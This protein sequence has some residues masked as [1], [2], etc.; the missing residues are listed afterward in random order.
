MAIVR[1]A[2]VL[3]FRR[4]SE[5]TGIEVLLGHPGGPLFARRDD[6]AWSI[7]K[8]LYKT[9]EEPRAAAYREFTEETGL[10]V[11]PGREITLGEARM[12]TGKRLTV[13]AV[14]GDLDPA[15]AHSNT[16]EMEWPPRSGR[17]G[18]FPEI[19]RVAWFDPDTARRKLARGQSE[20]V[21]RLISSPDVAGTAH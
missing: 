20:F 19:D 4:P 9:D 18:T 11:P 14:E 7:L 16:F 6:G 8:G 13:F 5:T 21:D 10:P 12:P 15:A 1:S 17:S 2:G 3:L